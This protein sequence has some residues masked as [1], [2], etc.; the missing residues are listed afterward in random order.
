MQVR[1]LGQGMAGKGRGGEAG[2][3]QGRGGVCQAVHFHASRVGRGE[4][5]IGKEIEG[6]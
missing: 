4:V 2:V 6:R 3:G 5:E 1:G